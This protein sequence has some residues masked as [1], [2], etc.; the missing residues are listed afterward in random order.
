[1]LNAASTC[2]ALARRT[3]RASS[4][5]PA[6]LYVQRDAQRQIVAVFHNPGPGLEPVANDAAELMSFLLEGEKSPLFEEMDRD[7]I[8]V[9]EDLIDLLIQNNVIRLTDLPIAAQQK[10]LARKSLRGRQVG[11]HSLVN[12][13]D[14][15]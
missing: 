5:E 4:Q 1:M 9:L 14:V 3:L 7:Y 15:I 12:K 8:R 10:L 2:Y 6:M 13:T 11:L